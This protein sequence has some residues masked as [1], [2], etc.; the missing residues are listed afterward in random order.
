MSARSL[1]RSLLL[2]LLAL[3]SGGC[4]DFQPDPP[5]GPGEVPSPRLVSVRI[6]YRQ[7]NGCQNTSLPCTGPVVFF[8]SWM[9]AS[10]PFP[11]TPTPGTFEWSGVA[12]RVPVNFPPYD[13]P[14]YVRVFDPYLQETAT[15]GVTA[16][17]L[18]VGTQV[19]TILDASGTPTESGLIYVDDNGIGRN[20]Y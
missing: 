17:R 16:S 18:T 4:W 19:I 20:P 13:I 3:S 5:E 10:E 9:R 11:L 15:G 7:P 12:T 2:S 1:G 6:R 14:Y 8:G